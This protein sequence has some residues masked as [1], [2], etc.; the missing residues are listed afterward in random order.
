[1]FLLPSSLPSFLLTIALGALPGEVANVKPGA[2]GGRGDSGLGVEGRELLSGEKAL[3]CIGIW[4]A[5]WLWDHC[6]PNSNNSK[7]LLVVSWLLASPWEPFFFF[8][9]FPEF[10]IHW[11]GYKLAFPYLIFNPILRFILE[12]GFPKTEL[13]YQSRLVVILE[14]YGSSSVEIAEDCI[15]HGDHHALM[16]ELFF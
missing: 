5:L 13:W 4:W 9:P 16:L 14:G 3:Y 8:F 6:A 1:M 15:S 10:S 12:D 11:E 7:L 2:R